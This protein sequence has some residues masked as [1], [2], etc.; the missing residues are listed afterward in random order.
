MH[1]SIIYPSICVSTC[2]FI[3]SRVLL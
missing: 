3:L 1:V 2:L